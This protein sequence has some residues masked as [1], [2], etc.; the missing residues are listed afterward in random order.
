MLF[1]PQDMLDE[2]KAFS[3]VLLHVGRRVDGGGHPTLALMDTL[4]QHPFEK[5][6]KKVLLLK[7]A[8]PLLALAGKLLIV[9]VQQFVS[10]LTGMCLQA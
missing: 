1:F 7:A 9:S 5:V 6:Q 2:G 8:L 4:A 3:A 10:E